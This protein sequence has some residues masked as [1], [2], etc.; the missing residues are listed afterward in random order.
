[1]ENEIETPWYRQ[2][3]PWLIMAFPAS[4]VVAGITTVIIATTH[5]DNLVVDNYYKQG[6]A[7]N[8]TIDQQ[9]AAQ[10]LG[11]SAKVNIND[12]GNISL[13]L[14][15]NQPLNLP[16]LKLSVVHATLA[17]L[18]QTVYLTHDSAESY[19]GRLANY[20]SGKWHFMLEPADQSWR[21]EKI[22]SMPV[23]QWVM[24]PAN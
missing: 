15:S 10:Q 6:L 22:V 7:I 12:N 9:Q 21:I 19:T 14:I 3:W 16:V 11:I 4:A 23:S 17:E 5:R 18:D 13:E 24:S 2:F 20:K 8:K 1:M